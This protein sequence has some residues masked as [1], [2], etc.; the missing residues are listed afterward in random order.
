MGSTYRRKNKMVETRLVRFKQV[1]KR[2]VIRREDQ[3]EGSQTARYRGK[4]KKTVRKTIMKV[5]KIN[6][7]DRNIIFERTL[8]CILMHV[9]NPT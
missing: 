3:M 4:S 8:W 5:L 7:L 1:E 6:K 2:Y 9:A